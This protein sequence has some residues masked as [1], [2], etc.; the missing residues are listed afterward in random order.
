VNLTCILR[1]LLSVFLAGVLSAFIPAAS[2][3]AEQIQY[4]PYFGLLHAHTEHSGGEGAVEYAFSRASQV[5]QL[6]FF[7]VTDYSHS[8]DN[9]KAGSIGTDGSGVSADWAAGKA[10]AAAVTTE[11][12]VGIYGYEM[13]YPDDYGLGHISTFHTP[14]WISR[15]QNG[16]ETLTAYYDA[17][18]TVPTSVSQFNHPGWDLGYFSNF[19]SRT[20]SYDEAIALLELGNGKGITTCEFYTTALDRGWHVAPTLSQNDFFGK[21]GTGSDARTVILAEALTEECLYD[22]M[23]NRRCYATE[24]RDLKISYTLNGQVMGSIIPWSDTITIEAALSDATD[25]GIAVLEVVSTEGTTIHKAQFS[26]QTIRLTLPGAA[27]YYFLRI[28]QPD[29]DLAVTAPVWMETP[30]EE[31]PTETTQP[32]PSEPENAGPEEPEESLPEET[33]PP[34]EALDVRFCFGLLHGHTDLSDGRGTVEEAYAAAA[35]QKN[36]DFYAVTDHSNSF[37]N[38][39]S[40]EIHTDAASISESWARGKA[41]AQAATT[42]DFVGIFGFEMTWPDDRYLGHITTFSTPGFLSRNREDMENLTDYYKALITVPGSVS[43]FCHPGQLGTFENFSHHSADYDQA[44][45]LLEIG[46]EGRFDALDAYVKALDAGWHL[47]PTASH[48]DHEG[49]F[50]GLNAA[51][52]V[53]LAPE[54]TEEALY[55]AMAQRRVYATLDSDLSLY[56]TLDGH[57]MGDI[58]PARDSHRLSLLLQD[59]TDPGTATVEVLSDGA[60]TLLCCPMPKSGTLELTLP[61]GKHYYFLRITQ[62][63]GDIAVT[64]PVWT[65]AYENVGVTDFSCDTLV[66][67]PG[68]TLTLTLTLS[69]EETLPFLLQSLTLLANGTPAYR[70]EDPGTI[71]PGSTQTLT[72]PYSQ[73]SAGAVTLRAEAVGT[74]GGISRTLH[75]ELTLHFRAKEMVR[76]ILVDIGH[77]SH[78]AGDFNSLETLARDAGMTM[79]CFTGSLPEDGSILILPPP[80]TTYEP[81]FLQ[82][83]KIFCARGGSLVVCGCSEQQNPQAVRELNRLLQLIGSSMTIRSDTALDPVQNKE[84][85]EEIYLTCFNRDAFFCGDITESQYYVNHFGATVDPGSGIWLVKGENTTISSKT[86]E[87]SPVLLAWEELSSGTHILASGSLF[88][89]DNAMPLPKNRW[90]PP[91]ANQT[92]LEA[93]LGITRGKF[94]I[95]DIREVRNGQENTL[96]HIKGYTT[97]GTS[98]RYNTFPDT[99]YLQDD[100]GGIAITPFRQSDVAVGTPMVAAGYLKRQEGNLVFMPVD[101][102]FPDERA[103]RYVPETINHSRAVDYNTYGGQLLQVEAKVTAVTLTEDGLGVRRF[104]LTDDWGDRITVMIEETIFSGAYGTN[105]LASQVKIGRTVRA[106]GLL[107]LDRNGIPVIRVRNCE[108]VVWVPPIPRPGSKDN[109]YTGDPIGIWAA[110]LCVSVFGILLVSRRQKKRLDR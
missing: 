76:G 34:L 14:G 94:P 4:Q 5:E 47:A 69:N 45:P 89:A 82:Q 28:T 65:E 84:Q 29:G 68:Q 3:A 21:F 41:A 20:D 99:I 32:T 55:E 93:L 64:A 100:T 67:L 102:D 36:M 108:E 48:N 70:L 27:G 56:Y 38:H 42:S 44:L 24:D 83:V 97:S 60:Q 57:L 98:N 110:T 86:G 77:S 33:R 12:F 87:I 51:R 81:E 1:G 62:S 66:P 30:K 43:Q 40:A 50:G 74:I 75:A 23:K 31:S 61:G 49:N 11:N 58:L 35:Q 104:V 25:G 109:P 18:T 10:A 105:T 26:G 72:I 80:E 103:Y 19:A 16:F 2:N 92:I 90:D 15:N 63:D 71:G 73:S 91:T 59:P 46:G 85:P 101:Y 106:M 6:D 22:A 37:D 95:T 8:L 52:T 13:C 88:P 9:D 79:T 54:L 78:S 107:H 96:Y 7:A 17:L 53:I 39:L